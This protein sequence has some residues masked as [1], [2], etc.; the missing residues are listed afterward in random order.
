MQ[1]ATFRQS[2]STC[3]M[4]LCTYSFQSDEH[5]TISA[6]PVHS[7]FMLRCVD[8]TRPCD[9]DAPDSSFQALPGPPPMQPTLEL[10]NNFHSLLRLALLIDHLKS[11]AATD[12]HSSEDYGHPTQKTPHFCS[13][14]WPV[15]EMRGQLTALYFAS[16]ANHVTTCGSLSCVHLTLRNS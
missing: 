15:D 13:Y 16:W 10:K 3:P 7:I 8:K 11:V 12:L 5:R 6:S 14:Q 1:R 9:V 4:F 2:S